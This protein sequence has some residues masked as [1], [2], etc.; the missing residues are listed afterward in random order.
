[1][2][3][4]GGGDS[5]RDEADDRLSSGLWYERQRSWRL[6][7]LGVLGRGGIGSFWCVWLHPCAVGLYERRG[8]V[9]IGNG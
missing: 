9:H 8:T 5:A 7:C 6:R 2:R 3:G 1:M 4:H